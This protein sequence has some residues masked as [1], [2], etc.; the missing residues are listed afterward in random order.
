MTCLAI[1]LIVVSRR[2]I[3]NS[4]ILHNTPANPMA[5]TRTRGNNVQAEIIQ[6][7][8]IAYRACYYSIFQFHRSDRAHQYRPCSARHQR[9]CRKRPLLNGERAEPYRCLSCPIRRSKHKNP[10]KIGTNE[11]RRWGPTATDLQL[12]NQSCCAG[13]QIVSSWRRKRGFRSNSPNETS[14]RLAERPNWS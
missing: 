5:A 3:E 12:R 9:P 14:A 8:R 4:E 10:Q 6:Y 13:L 11:R 7:S 1:L 2:N